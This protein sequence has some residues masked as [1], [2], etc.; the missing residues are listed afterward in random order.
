[1]SYII[2]KATVNRKGFSFHKHENYE[3]IV[4]KKGV[5]VCKHP[6]HLLVFRRIRVAVFTRNHQRQFRAY[7]F[8]Q[9]FLRACV[10]V[11]ACHRVAAQHR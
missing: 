5:A 9:D 7:G 2:E 8:R 11:V 4:F 3:I 10:C 1:M 6:Y